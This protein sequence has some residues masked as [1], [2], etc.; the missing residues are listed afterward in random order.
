[1]YLH[2]TPK[3]VV[4]QHVYIPDSAL[5]RI[6]GLL[7]GFIGSLTPHNGRPMKI[8]YAIQAYRRY[9]QYVNVS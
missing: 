7:H 3:E 2:K 6:S 5:A 9:R 1:M 8:K 4:V